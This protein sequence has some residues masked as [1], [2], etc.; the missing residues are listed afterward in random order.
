MFLVK[1]CRIHQKN[2]SPHSFGRG[3]TNGDFDSFGEFHGIT[4]KTPMYI[5]S[6]FGWFWEETQFHTNFVHLADL[7]N[8]D[9]TSISNFGWI[10]RKLNVIR[11]LCICLI[12]KTLTW[13]VGQK[14]FPR[15]DVSGTLISQTYI[16]FLSSTNWVFLLTTYTINGLCNGHSC[17][18]YV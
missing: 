7:K 17:Y 15:L 9:M 16:R 2:Q 13:L 5:I 1:C 10:G 8:S 3:P 12:W 14:G 4:S 11:I 6:N 18:Q